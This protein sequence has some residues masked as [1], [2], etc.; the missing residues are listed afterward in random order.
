MQNPD[1][2]NATFRIASD[3]VNYTS[4]H[5]FLTGK[6]GTGKT[7]FL[8]FI[9]DTTRKN[10]SVVAPTGVAAINAGGVTM[11]SF[12][13]LP[14]E[15]FIP[16][17]S[18][19]GMNTH[20]ADKHNLFSKIQLS[21]SKREVMEELQL[22]VIDEVSML[23]C[24]KLDAIDT[25]LRHVRKNNIPFGGVQVLF[26]GDMYQLPPVAPDEEWRI[27]KEHYNS[28]FFF[29]AHVIREINLVNI[30]LKKIYR[31]NEQHFIDLLNNVRNNSVSDHD[32]E[33]LHSRYIP[34]YKSTPDDYFIT[35]ST[36]NYKA[37]KINADELK[38]LSG[39]E[40]IFKG[41]IEGEFSDKALPTEQNLVLKAGAQVMFIKNDTGE[42][43][44]YYNGKIATVKKVLKDSII[45]TMQD[46]GT[47]FELKK[48]TWENIRYTFNKEKN[49]IEEETLG[50]FTQYP[51]R[52]AWAITIHKSQ[53]LTFTKV[54][55]D[56]GQSFAAGQVYVAL[57]RCATL[58]GMVLLSKIY[59]GVISTDE[60]IVEFSA[61]ESKM[62]ILE[63][64]LI[65]EKKKYLDNQLIGTFNYAHII[66]LLEEFVA[67]VPNKKLPDIKGAVILA[68]ELNNKAKQQYVVTE[69]FKIQLQAMLGDDPHLPTIEERVTKGIIWMMQNI[70]NDLLHP[71]ANH[72]SSLQYAAK[73][74]KYTKH[75][76]ELINALSNFIRHL[77]DTSYGDLVF[78][79][80]K[81]Y[82]LQFIPEIKSVTK[83]VSGG[84]EV[85]E[86]YR[87]TLGLFREGLN[88]GEIAEKRGLA[89][90][91]IESHLS[92]YVAT[93]EINIYDIYSDER[94]NMILQ[95]F[96]DPSVESINDVRQKLGSDYS[97]N[98]VRMIH[99][100]WKMM[101]AVNNH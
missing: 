88:I 53:G 84:Q 34:N 90:S 1:V 44:K 71:L 86:T 91:T 18:G 13:Q 29:D 97:Y 58:E 49:I 14:F 67:F 30:E 22:L 78:I 100:Y 42:E 57:S 50:K 45:V 81:N 62:E 72:L 52:L 38:K 51:V 16:V 59:P 7:T 89:L 31:Q 69:K 27:L 19:F 35:I 83:R 25:I 99:E 20:V 61:Q 60:R 21:G 79:K 8:K 65:T 43:R 87:T 2:T 47:E 17:K 11:H 77:N 73:V 80:D 101:H 28:P 95:I 70:S 4:Q 5:I 93:G 9:K 55:I 82:Y 33:L 24:D 76:N 48:E 41:D 23:R 54:I 37:D 68:R 92:R 39:P 40:F 75:V 74:R 94:I 6:A 98:Q 32:Y 36:H 3:L 15:P 56:A 63:E 85:G 12:F 66:K 10:I 26:I 64:V 96:D 46:D